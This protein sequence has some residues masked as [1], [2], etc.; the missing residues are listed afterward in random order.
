MLN[1]VAVREILESIIQEMTKLC[2]SDFGVD[3][4]PKMVSIKNSIEDCGDPGSRKLLEKKKVVSCLI[5]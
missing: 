2:K 1:R 3:S 5:V 4:S